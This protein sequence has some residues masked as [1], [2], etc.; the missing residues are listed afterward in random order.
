MPLIDARSDSPRIV[1]APGKK[2]NP[3]RFPLAKGA[4]RRPTRPALPK[5]T[6]GDSAPAP[7]PK[8]GSILKIALFATGCAGIVAEFVLST[9]ATYLL[10]NAIVQW[11]LVMSLMLFAMGLG[12]RISR[13]VRTDL[14]DAFIVIEI[15]L[16]LLC[17]GSALTAYGLAG[18]TE[19]VGALIYLH[20]TAIGVLIGFEIPLV[21]RINES[22]EELRVN[23]SAVME[24]DYYGALLGG[25]I[26]AFVA[27]PRFGLTYTPV[28]LGGVNFLVAALVLWRFFP[29]VRRRRTLVSAFA[30]SA[31]ALV[32]MGAFSRPVIVYGEQR[33][34][35]DQ[36]VYARRTPYQKIVMTRW[37]E[38]YWLY[39][40]GQQQFSTVDEEKY[41][42]PLVH[43]VMGIPPTV[44][45]V[46]V[47][48]GGDGLAAREVLKYPNVEAIVLVDMDPAMTRLAREHPVL[49][50]INRGALNDPRVRVVNRDAAHFVE[51]TDERFDAIVIDLP[52]P[53]SVD[54][55]H[56]YSRGF[57]RL[58]H[59]RLARGGALVAQAASPFF[60]RR[61]FLCVLKTIR[62]SGFSALPFHN[63]I[64]T[65]G[66]WG[67]V[68]GIREEDGDE[69]TLRRRLLSMDFGN[70]E[71]RFVDRDAMISMLHF[72]KGV[73]DEAELSGIVV[74]T[75]LEPVLF[76]YYLSGNW[77]VY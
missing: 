73:I 36:V 35:R 64:P 4:K 2:R 52:D 67:W 26:F 25:L 41:H 34:Y 48:G 61:A 1:F 16:S 42:E 11:T 29:L 54:I 20:A 62:A 44:R 9:L 31:A 14:V 7:F 32:A 50:S 38:D 13:W 72:G 76:R 22:Y 53:D 70:V 23:I 68:V 18:H 43:P 49:L 24:K 8:G 55:M 33:K 75:E 63:S 65:M 74:N 15:A 45:R 51:E 40:N 6:G 69:E 71:T 59:R 17:A 28:F 5:K 10:G 3:P 39:L 77:S 30:L 37:R 58:L 66:Q 47:V 12:S 27:L 19:Y 56:V 46:L 21:T 57:Y 60:A